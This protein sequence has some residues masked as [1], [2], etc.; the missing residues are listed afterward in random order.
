MHH[1]RSET[2]GENIMNSAACF[3]ISTSLSRY[4]MDQYNRR[5]QEP[6]NLLTSRNC[7]LLSTALLSGGSGAN[8]RKSLTDILSGA[9]I[10]AW[11]QTSWTVDMSTFYQPILEVG[12]F[13]AILHV[14]SSVGT[15]THSWTSLG[16]KACRSYYTF[17]RWGMK[18][19]LNTTCINIDRLTMKHKIRGLNATAKFS[20]GSHSSASQQSAREA[21]CRTPEMRFNWRL[22]RSDSGYNS[23]TMSARVSSIRSWQDLHQSTH[24]FSSNGTSQLMIQDL[25]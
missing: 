2:N 5:S 15:V 4:H 14:T 12:A 21:S 1:R 6:Y 13:L 16:A 7:K 18:N 9:N 3:T 25:S 23:C 19:K 17:F 8:W 20:H 10:F 24:F 11:R 22:S